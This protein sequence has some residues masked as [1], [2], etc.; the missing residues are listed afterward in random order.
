[1]FQFAAEKPTT[2]LF[3]DTILDRRPCP[4]HKAAIGEP[5]WVLERS[6][7]GGA[8]A[9]CNRRARA[10]GFNHPI[11]PKSLRLNRKPKTP[12]KR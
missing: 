12:K 1:M 5:C 7:R 9:V 6:L 2:E 4:K 10:A 11:D 3:L 8:L